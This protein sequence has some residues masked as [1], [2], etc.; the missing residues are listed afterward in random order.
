MVNLDMDIYAKTR[1]HR[2]IIRKIHKNNLLK[3]KR[4]LKR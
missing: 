3:S 1:N 4:I 2:K